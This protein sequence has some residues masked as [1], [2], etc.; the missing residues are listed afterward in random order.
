MEAAAQP[1]GFR[2]ISAVPARALA[3]RSANGAVWAAAF[4]LVLYLALKNG[5]FDVV[6]RSEVGIAVWWIVLVG[7]LV[8]AFAPGGES[9]L[10]RLMLVV[11]A[12]FAAWTALSLSWTESDGRTAIE[13]GK[14]TA[15]LGFFA[16]ALAVQ[17]AGRWRPLL[18]GVTAGIGTVTA[19]AVLS[20][21]EPSWFPQQAAGRY[22]HDIQARLLYPLNYSTGLGAFMAM[23]VPLLLNATASARTLVAQAF[24]AAALPIAVLGLWLTGSSLALPLTI[25]AVGAYLVLADDRLPK[26]A[27]LV[28][29]G[30]GAT[31][32]IVAENQ[33]HALDR[34]LNT[35]AAHQQGHELLAIGLIVCAG[36]VLLQL[37]LSL[38]VR[39][40]RR[41][42]WLAP[43][44]RAT[45][46]VAGAAALAA[47]LALIGLGASG[48]LGDRWDNFTH[49]SGSQGAT[50]QA[51]ITNLSSPGRYPYWRSAL[52]AFDSKPL[53]GT[54]PG[55]FEFWWARNGTG[56]GPVQDAHSLPLETLAELGIPG[57]ILLMGFCLSVVALGA[58]RTFRVP[59]RLRA[60]IAAA[61]AA[62][63]AFVAAA[64]VDWTWELG[65]VVA[66]FLLVA[67]IAV[68][69]GGE[70]DPAAPVKRRGGVRRWA[71]LV[72]RI[73]I[74]LVALASL[75]A[76]ALPLAGELD[77]Q[78]SQAAAA[79]GDLSSALSEAQNA[80]EVQPY[81]ATP[82]IQEA[83]VLERQGKLQAAL[84]AARRASSKEVTSWQVW[85]IV[86][87]LE[88]RAGNARAAVDA[89]RKA[90]SLAPRFSVLPS[91]RGSS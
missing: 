75:V 39:F 37:A 56:S 64:A 49:G 70:P 43:S 35:A 52:D 58:V 82:L 41:P 27:T 7:T 60:D 21:L 29:T 28:I 23:G 71:P 53:T 5:G 77:I 3:A 84:E 31:V 44:R 62:S 76:I 18:M 45:A 74:A 8:G 1:I 17:G 57:F 14:V 73:T 80:A 47:V 30:L 72:G 9:R 20:R 15:Y 36:V 69:G 10:G 16:L 40:S 32:L 6:Q 48:W 38:L 88:A 55:T 26:L 2:R 46:T 89:Y 22:Y 81:A 79:R 12:L 65:A 78:Q 87:R 33:R 42:R 67:A 19:L 86:S 85:L 34:G 50:R 54:G 63:V 24:A 66:A 83:L 51:E 11:L 68:A 25:L 4:L 13:L 59:A 90:H 61:T 91:P